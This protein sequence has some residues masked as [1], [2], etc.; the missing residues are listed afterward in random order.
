MEEERILKE[1]REKNEKRIDNGKV[2][3]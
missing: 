2:T 1:R 3:H